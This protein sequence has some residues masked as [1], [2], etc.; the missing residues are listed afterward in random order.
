MLQVS[1]G[2]R[3]RSALQATRMVRYP[4]KLQGIDPALGLQAK[5][6][7]ATIQALLRAGKPLSSLMTVTNV[8]GP[9]RAQNKPDYP[10]IADPAR[11]AR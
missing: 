1:N 5:A 9:C 6:S 10:V 11:H 2:R 7:G 4:T 8:P 3:G